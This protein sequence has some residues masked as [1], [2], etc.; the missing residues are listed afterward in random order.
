M[1][2]T[3]VWSE[4]LENDIANHLKSDAVGAEGPLDGAMLKLFQNDFTP[5][6][7]AVPA[8]FT[9]ADFTGYAAV[10]ITWAAVTRKNL[11]AVIKSQLVS[12]IATGSA[13]TNVI[14]G[15]YVTNAAG[16][17]V[18]A[19]FLYNASKPVSGAGA[20]IDVI[21]EVQIKGPGV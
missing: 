3:A 21:A 8:D 13:I 2:G 20:S 12:F 7:G 15:W 9:E 4:A 16:D 6:K 18:Y 11:A 19:S 17:T 5:T 14:F 1:A 10:A